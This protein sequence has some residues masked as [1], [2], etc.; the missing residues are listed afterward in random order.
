MCGNPTHARGAK[1][2]IAMRR[3]FPALLAL[4]ALLLLSLT[5][6]RAA[7]DGDFGVFD[8]ESDTAL[9]I[10][11]PGFTGYKIFTLDN[12]YRIVI[13]AT[14]KERGAQPTRRYS[15][16][17][18]RIKEIR[19]RLHD[20]M[21]RFVCEPAEHIAVLRHGALAPFEGGAGNSG[22]IIM[23]TLGTPPQ[24]DEAPSREDV[25][26][27][28]PPRS[29]DPAPPSLPVPVR[30]PGSFNPTI[31]IDAGHGGKDPGAQGR[32]RGVREKDVTLRFAEEA[33]R[34]LRASGRYKARLTRDEDFFVPLQDRVRIAEEA[35]ADFFISLHAD[36]IPNRPDT[37]G[38]SV[39]T[40]SDVASDKQAAALAQKENLAGEAIGTD[41]TFSDDVTSALVRLIQ[42]DSMNR[43][44]LFAETFL[45]EGRGRFAMLP[46]NP[47]RFAGFRVL[48]SARVPSVLIELGYLSNRKDEAAL[49]SEG[50]RREV[51]ETI[52]RTL[53]AMFYKNGGRR[54]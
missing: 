10:P 9:I 38:L 26:P 54:E 27:V 40:L 22:H 15:S 33:A 3:R 30:K 44:A 23:V 42:R 16:S 46:Q 17:S 29:G 4:C 32:Y 52:L 6:L 7:A 35:D 18:P 41:E 21:Y 8:R 14:T 12:P 24:E 37:Q 53:D 48:T 2:T 47:H 51:A 50:R 20:R 28:V 43:S 5:P 34:A 36:S 13:D 31:V 39:Y 1:T 49:R 25:P 45:R 11:V 19:T